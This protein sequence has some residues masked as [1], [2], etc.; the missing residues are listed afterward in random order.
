[1]AATWMIDNLQCLPASWQ[2]NSLRYEQ[3]LK[4][5]FL[6]FAQRSKDK[7]NLGAKN[8][9]RLLTSSTSEIF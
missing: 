8:A 9:G 5:M 7:K 6:M 4:E 1:M 2:I 3:V